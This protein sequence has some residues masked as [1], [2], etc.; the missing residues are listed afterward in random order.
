MIKEEKLQE[1][2]NKIFDLVEEEYNLDLGACNPGPHLKTYKED[3][4]RNFMRLEL[5]D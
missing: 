5:I 1:I 3:R 4:E 2:K